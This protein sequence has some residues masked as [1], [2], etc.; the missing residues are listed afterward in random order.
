MMTL[1][2]ITQTYGSTS[3]MKNE[4]KEYSWSLK[5]MLPLLV[6]QL[7]LTFRHFAEKS[8]FSKPDFFPVKSIK[9]SG[10]KVKDNPKN[11]QTPI[12]GKKVKTENKTNSRYTK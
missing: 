7:L 10:N 6:L 2:H 1:T 8:M 9:T 3:I 5:G 11:T 12:L 4:P